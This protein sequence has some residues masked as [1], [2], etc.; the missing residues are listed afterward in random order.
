MSDTV[1]LYMREEGFR[2]ELYLVQGGIQCHSANGR[3]K[4]QL[5][6]MLFYLAHAYRRCT[7]GYRHH[8]YIHESEDVEERHKCKEILWKLHHRSTLVNTY[9][10]GQTLFTSLSPRTSVSDERISLH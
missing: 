8:H 4:P 2:L 1:G 3:G 10:R 5:W 9:A 6:T 7:D